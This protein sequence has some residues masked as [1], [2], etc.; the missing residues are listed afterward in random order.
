[1]INI[2]NWL[3]INIIQIS[4]NNLHIQKAI[5]MR[6][7]Q[8]NSVIEYDLVEN[9][10]LLL[11]GPLNEYQ[12]KN[13]AKVQFLNVPQNI[14]PNAPRIVVSSPNAILNISLVRFEIIS[15]IP[16]H[17]IEDISATILFSRN[18][19]DSILSQLWVPELKYKWLGFVAT[20]DFPMSGPEKTGLQLA[21]PFFDK[22]VNID[23]NGREL[24]SFEIRLGFKEP[25]YFINYKIH[26]FENRD[27][28]IDASKLSNVQRFF[29]LEDVSAVTSA[30]LRII[31]DINNK[32]NDV[33][34]NLSSDF[35][36]L[37]KELEKSLPKV[38]TDLNLNDLV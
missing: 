36:D 38:I 22:L 25:N 16:N 24:G 35:E 12:K 11:G 4:F 9:L 30:G 14:P 1:M 17:I 32:S 34:K 7:S 19:V 3:K 10:L 15:K 28:K 37:F 2:K 13:N 6:I 18:N 29:E 31:F 21:K 8:T 20:L 33:K 27:I 23:R 5:P 26:F